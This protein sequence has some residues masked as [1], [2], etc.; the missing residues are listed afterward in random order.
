MKKA[1]VIGLMLGLSMSI[2]AP[3]AYSPERFE[4]LSQLTGQSIEYLQA[5]VDQ[6]L[7]LGEIAQENG[8]YEAF[9]E[10]RQAMREA[11]LQRRIENGSLS[12]EEAD[13]I[14]E[15][16]TERDGLCHDGTESRFELNREFRMGMRRQRIR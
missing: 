13:Q 3:L 5:Q 15:R 4:T 9:R 2:I 10:A 7:G 1:S 11:M 12:P 8:V 14:R 6:G 16:F